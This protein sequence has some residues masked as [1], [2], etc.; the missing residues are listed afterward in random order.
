MLK[1]SLFLCFLTICL[2]CSPDSLNEGVSEVEAFDV[3]FLS[4]GN[5][6]FVDIPFQ[7]KVQSSEPINDIT[8]IFENSSQGITAGMPGTVLDEK[9]LTLNLHF[10]TIGKQEVKLEFTSISG[11]KTSKVL[12]FDVIRGNAVKVIGFKINSFYNMNGT[13]DSEYAN[14]DPNRLAD[15]IFSFQKLSTAHFSEPKQNMGYWYLSPIY[16][17]QQQIEWDLSKE[18]LYISDRSI[19]EIGIGDDDGNGIGEDL[20]R[21]HPALQI[22]LN[23]YRDTKPNT[24][25]LSNT[26][27]A[28]D[29]S[30]E[31]EW[32]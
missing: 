17:N 25:N 28:I 27:S 5:E 1:K 12:S 7:V 19:M 9:F 4:N 14:D 16:P 29:V 30:V 2:S 18:E 24:I 10:D 32:L 20:T 11:K 3:S 23:D 31:L 22:R 13:W 6:V 15:I 26:E 8:R 21:S